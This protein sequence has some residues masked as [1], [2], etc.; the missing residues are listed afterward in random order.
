MNLKNLSFLKIILQFCKLCYAGFL[1]KRVFSFTG[2]SEKVINGKQRKG[3][4]STQLD[5]AVTN[6]S[7]GTKTINM[8]FPKDTAT[9]DMQCTLVLK[10]TFT[11]KILI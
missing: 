10:Y 11:P 2:K 8:I 3:I 1:S 7:L 5:H 6:S 4:A 9:L